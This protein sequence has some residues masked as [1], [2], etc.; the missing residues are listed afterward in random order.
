MTNGKIDQARKIYEVVKEMNEDEQL[1]T[2]GAV[3]AIGAKSVL[4]APKEIQ[5]S[6]TFLEHKTN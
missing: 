3:Y 6:R 5:L 1:V 2:L 4:M